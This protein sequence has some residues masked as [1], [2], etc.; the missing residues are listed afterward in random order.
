MNEKTENKGENVTLK[1]SYAFALR[2]VGLHKHLSDEKKEFVLSRKVLDTGT[3]IGARVK[4]A[5]E[6]P[7][8]A[9]FVSEIGVALLRASETEY[10]LELLHDGGFLS[11]S[12]FNSIHADCVE[13]I[14]LLTKISKTAQPRT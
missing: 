5:Q 14:R 12:A 3:S 10:W 7:T 9:V 8:K 1:K 4:A 11:E 6:A 2:V 13:L